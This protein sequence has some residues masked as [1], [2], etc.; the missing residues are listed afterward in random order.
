MKRQKGDPVASWDGLNPQLPWLYTKETEVFFNNCKTHWQR[1]EVAG[2][3]RKV[4]F[5]EDKLSDL[6]HKY[7]LHLLETL[8]MQRSPKQK[9]LPAISSEEVKSLANYRDQQVLITFNYL[10]KAFRKVGPL[11][12]RNLN[13]KH[14]FVPW[15]RD[16]FLCC[17]EHW[18]FFCQTKNNYTRT[19]WHTKR[20]QQVGQSPEVFES[21]GRLQHNCISEDCL[22]RPECFV[23]GNTPYNRKKMRDK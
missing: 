15:W 7:Y 1:L 17:F 9:T 18:E 10:I 16:F 4:F 23:K 5:Q 21:V 2:A 19:K 6:L 12:P 8:E 20:E 22:H 14:I 13:L 3:T 11:I